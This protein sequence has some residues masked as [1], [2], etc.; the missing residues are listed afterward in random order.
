MTQYN[1]DLLSGG[2][3]GFWDIFKNAIFDAINS[4]YGYCGDWGIAIIIITVIFRILILPITIKQ[5][6]STYKMQKFT[7]LIKE[8]QEKYADDRERQN[9][10]LTKLYTEAKFN[11]L[12]GC[13]P[14]LL[15]MPLFMALFQV[16]RGLD[17]LI[18]NAGHSES[19]L[20][21][22][23]LKIIPDLSESL[24]MVFSFSSEGIKTSLP[25]LIMLLLFSA[26]MLVPMLI[27]QSTDQQAMTMTAAMS[28]MMLFAGW[29]TPAGVLLYW[30]A[31]SIIG[32]SQ[33]IISKIVNERKDR[34]AEKE[35]IE[36]KPVKVNVE[37][38]ERK[39]RP[40]KSK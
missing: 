5:S 14:T 23:F 34:E 32:I 13:L 3:L 36:I 10:E 40:R 11:P 4:V 24:S 37:R 28:V 6:N 27:N 12:S 9:E 21:A 31:S 16:L 1:S 38:R 25:Y 8:I 18:I 30:D 29:R 33:Q 2:I 15:Q 17:Q 19:V 7:P 20:P 39:S 22:T 26:S 35:Q